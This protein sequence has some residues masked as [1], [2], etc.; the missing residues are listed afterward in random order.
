MVNP[1]SVSAG[2]SPRKYFTVSRRHGRDMPPWY[3]VREHNKTSRHF[4]LLAPSDA[5]RDYAWAIV[6]DVWRTK[7]IAWSVSTQ[8]SSFHRRMKARNIVL[9][10]LPHH[11]SLSRKIN[12]RITEEKPQTSNTRWYHI[13]R[14]PDIQQDSLMTRINTPRKDEDATRENEM[15]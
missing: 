11:L 10:S 15:W 13:N 14:N 8:L 12:H 2:F 4:I 1:R 3:Q 6:G 5:P 7:E 9:Q